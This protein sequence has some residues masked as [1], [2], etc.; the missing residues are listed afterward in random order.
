MGTLKEVRHFICILTSAY[1][2]QARPRIYSGP[3]ADMRDGHHSPH[4]KQLNLYIRICF[5][6]YIVCIIISYIFV[7]A[8]L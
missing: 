2:G 7:L 5:K 8:I 1:G 6:A 4:Q 3:A